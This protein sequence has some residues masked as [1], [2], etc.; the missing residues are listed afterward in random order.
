MGSV[1]S[2]PK[3]DIV[4]TAAKAIICA[5]SLR[6]GAPMAANE[7][8]N[9]FTVSLAHLPATARQRR[10]ALAVAAILLVGFG[11]LA[12][13]AGKPLQPVNGFIPALDS[14]IFVTDFITAVLLLTQFSI[15]RSRALLALACGYLFAALMVMAHELSFPGAFWLSGNLGGGVQ[16]TIR[17]Y[18]FWHLG[19]PVALFAYIWLRDEH[20]TKAIAHESAV[21]AIS[22]SVAS[23]F[24]LAVGLTWL[25][26]AGDRLLPSLQQYP[27]QT[28]HLVSWA[29]PIVLLIYAAA[30]AVLWMRA[31]SVLDQWLMVVAL[32]S[33]VELTITAEFGNA[34]FS[35]GFYT[36]RMFSLV[37]STVVLI[38]LL[39]E[40]TRL[41]ARLARA[42][43]LLE[44]ERNNRL[45]SFEAIT[46]SIAHEIRQ[47]LTAI[48]ANSSAALELLT[49]TPPD[50][51]E[52]KN[53]LRDIA[54]D[55][56]RT[57]KAVDS[58]QSLFHR[59]NQKRELVNVNEIVREV[60][61]SMRIELKD[62]GV[63]VRPQLRTQVPPVPGNR[64]Q[65]QQVILNL[66]HNAVEA[67]ARPAQQTRVLQ[68]RTELYGRNAIALAVQDSGPGIRPDRLNDIFEAFVTTKSDGMGLGLAICR[69]I[70]EHH[71]GQLTASSDGQTGA[72]FQIVLPI[73]L[74]DAF[75]DGLGHGQ[76]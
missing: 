19:L 32:A 63:T 73:Q 34:R 9:K 70:I 23:V 56:R 30:L 46:A 28:G 72:Q 17:L 47:P 35:L 2:D 74:P 12:P 8:S 75:E 24:V 57:N 65:L 69:T 6:V 33:I 29:T 11:A 55:T 50:L 15:S 54:E 25:A 52:T 58:V 67:M 53:A 16:T 60:L 71:G 39:E 36:G 3:A 22:S 14:T 13:F 40:T 31:R 10:F 64:N 38:V 49:K 21:S 76:G 26:A 18:F 59:S 37:T 20:D 44:R 61:Q 43:T 62:H 45:M 68:L 42:N 51:T 66:I 7:K 48:S 1:E 4:A 41:Y 5:L 27:Y